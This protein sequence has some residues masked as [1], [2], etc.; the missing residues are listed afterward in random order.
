MSFKFRGP[1]GTTTFNV[2]YD[3]H[4]ELENIFRANKPTIIDILHETNDRKF[5]LSL[6]G[7]E[8]SPEPN[9]GA[10]RRWIVENRGTGDKYDVTK[11]SVNGPEGVIHEYTWKIVHGYAKKSELG[12]H[13]PYPLI[14][15]PGDP[16]KYPIPKPYEYNEPVNKKWNREYYQD[17]VYASSLTAKH[18]CIENS[19][20]LSACRV[21]NPFPDSGL[22]R[23]ERLGN[24]R[25]FD[26]TREPRR[27][28]R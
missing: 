18:R 5:D 17:G 19:V 4:K 8:I 23:V 24:V 3:N 14:D 13:R 25:F 7:F 16:A 22:K 11:T 10:N 26:T 20:I 28:T 2:L 21:L 12:A 1:D 6:V 27:S 15:P 9:S